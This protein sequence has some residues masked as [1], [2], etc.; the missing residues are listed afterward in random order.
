[1]KDNH[2]FV[3]A[4]NIMSTIKTTNSFFDGPE[5][6]HGCIIF[7]INPK[8]E[9]K[10]LIINTFKNQDGFR[11]LSETPQISIIC[12]H[13]Q[14]IKALAICGFYDNCTSDIEDIVQSKDYVIFSNLF[15][16]IHEFTETL[17]Y[18][19]NIRSGFYFKLKPKP[20]F[21]NEQGTI[22][23]HTQRLLERTPGITAYDH[24]KNEFI[25]ITCKKPRDLMLLFQNCCH[26]IEWFESHFI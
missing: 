3:R 2:W 26:Q 5:P 1:M 9:V 16:L 17:P 22:I 14:F 7:T 21:T 25:S 10:E 18:R 12:F 6:E 13:S 4:F 24:Y 11:I 20:T 23:N 19:D 8:K 15:K